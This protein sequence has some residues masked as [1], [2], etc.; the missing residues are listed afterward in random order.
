MPVEINYDFKGP[1]KDEPSEKEVRPNLR[2]TRC[3]ANCK[4]YTPKLN[5]ANRGYCRYPDPSSKTLKKRLG[6]KLDRKLIDATWS[7]AHA[8][9][10]CD[11][12]EI[13][14]RGKTLD[15]ISEWLDKEILNDGTIKD[16]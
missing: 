2:V 6:T 11:L 10:L 16:K 14:G 9:M 7:R 5:R 1:E 13:R 12:Y 4:F 15:L 3:C 8:T